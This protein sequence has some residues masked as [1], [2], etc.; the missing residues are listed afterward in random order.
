MKNQEHKKPGARY[1]HDIRLCCH[2]MVSY[3]RE[4]KN[5]TP[6][7]LVRR[8]YIQI[9]PITTEC[10][11]HDVHQHRSLFEVFMSPIY[12]SVCSTLRLR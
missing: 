5:S 3:V 11:Q 7:P 10:D 8:N 12:S 6:C 2:E 9:K 1:V 4:T